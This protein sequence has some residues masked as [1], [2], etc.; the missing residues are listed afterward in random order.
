[1]TNLHGN[2]VNADIFT[3][4]YKL[5]GLFSLLDLTAKCKL[6]N[7]ILFII[8]CL[9]LVLCKH[10]IGCPPL[11]WQGSTTCRSPGV[12]VTSCAIKLLCKKVGQ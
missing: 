7:T 3:V 11:G 5:L 1:M 4:Y 9:T 10:R 8:A 2:V 6:N 12:H